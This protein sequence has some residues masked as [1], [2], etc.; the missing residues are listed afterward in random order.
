MARVNRTTSTTGGTPT[1]THTQSEKT[2]PNKYCILFLCLIAPLILHMYGL[3]WH[4]Y[5][6]PTQT[7]QLPVNIIES[8]VGCWI[9][10]VD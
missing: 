5:L 9:V 10:F 2:F 4:I 3:V 7:F 1:H 6:L 8:V